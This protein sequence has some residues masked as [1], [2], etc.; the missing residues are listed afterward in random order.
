MASA[1]AKGWGKGLAERQRTELPASNAGRALA[2]TRLIMRKLKNL[3]RYHALRAYLIAIR[4]RW[5]L[6]KSLVLQRVMCEYAPLSPRY[7][8]PLTSQP[9]ANTA[10]TV[11]ALSFS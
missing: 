7:S 4:L 10:Q 8:G 2:K 11:A 9:S 6:E 3:R 1:E 5:S